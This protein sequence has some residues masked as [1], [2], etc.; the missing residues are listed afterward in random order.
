M[1]LGLHSSVQFA[2]PQHRKKPNGIEIWCKEA[3]GAT[4]Y[5]LMIC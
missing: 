5:L 3:R 2:F 4:S 1:A